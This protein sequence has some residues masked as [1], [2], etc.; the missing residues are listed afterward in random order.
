MLEI[1]RVKESA[2]QS[3]AK[4]IPKQSGISEISRMKADDGT[5]VF[6]LKNKTPKRLNTALIPGFGTGIRRLKEARYNFEF[7]DMDELL[8]VLHGDT[9]LMFASDYLPGLIEKSV[10]NAIP[11]TAKLAVTN[12]TYVIVNKNGDLVPIPVQ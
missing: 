3:F 8:R 9:R 12:D 2:I 10:R 7:E 4:W 5:V 11:V 1:Y 6:L